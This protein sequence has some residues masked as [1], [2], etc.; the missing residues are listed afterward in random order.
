[1]NIKITAD[2]CCNSEN[3]ICSSHLF[4]VYSFHLD[5]KNPKISMQQKETQIS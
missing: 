5:K 3:C 1:M 2:L 4:K